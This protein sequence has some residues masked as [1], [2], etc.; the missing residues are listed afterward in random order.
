[1]H[2]EGTPG[3][4]LLNPLG[5]VHGGWALTLIDTVT[6]CAAHSILPAGV[7]YTTIETKARGGREREGGGGGRGVSGAMVAPNFSRAI[8][9]ETGAVRAEGRV[10]GKGRTIISCEGRIID[11]AGSLLLHGTS[12]L[13][14]LNSSRDDR[15]LTSAQEASIDENGRNQRTDELAEVGRCT[16]A[17]SPVHVSEHLSG[18]VS[19][20]RLVRFAADAGPTGERRYA[21]VSATEAMRHDLPF[22]NRAPGVSESAH[23]RLPATGLS[24]PTT[25]SFGRKRRCSSK[26]ARAA[27]LLA[28]IWLTTASPISFAAP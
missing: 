14:V 13:M 16:S 24:A 10:V 17:Y 8:T 5:I 15:V 28:A 9:A 19:F 21:M 18:N 20:G 2:F 22:A 7:G 27:G 4:H 6:G 12:T 11:A 26:P 23:G 25:A 3:L 1:M